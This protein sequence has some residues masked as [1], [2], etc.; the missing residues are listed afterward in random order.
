MRRLAATLALCVLGVF[1]AEVLADAAPWHRRR[2]SGLRSNRR[3]T[4]LVT[5]DDWPGEPVAPTE[6]DPERFARALR[7][8][9]GWMPP[10]RPARYTGYILEHAAHFE[11]DPF[12]IGALIHR[13]SRCNPRAE[14]MDGVGLTLVPSRMHWAYLRGGAYS[15]HVMEDGAW[16]ARELETGAF[17]FNDVRLRRAEENIYYAAA[18]LRVWRDQAPSL[19]DAFDQAPHRHY[20]SHWVWGDRVISDRAEDRILLD[21]RRLLQYYGALDAPEPIERH[22]LTWGP[23][24]DGVPRVVS[25]WIGAE[26]DGGERRHR[27]IDVE[28]VLGEP[29]HAIA[30]GRV[31]FAGVDMPGAANSQN[32]SREEIEAVPRQRLGRGGRYVCVNHAPADDAEHPWLRT[33]YMHLED[34]N[35]SWGDEVERGHV[36]GTVGR[37]GMVSSAPHLHLEIRAPEGELLDASVVLREY[38][39]GH[40]PDA[41][42]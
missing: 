25:S 3:A 23:P 41:E 16:T 34:V 17:P 9:C 32:M 21:R 13:M 26:R 18:I 35:V 36:L 19:K 15:Y 22:G 39:L 33:C 14:E 2:R 20:V 10:E 1:V 29:V 5:P 7:E 28:S 31:T 37:T 38:L 12:L 6:V 8:L 4:A 24:L 40:D 42:D 27:G 11:V 30:A